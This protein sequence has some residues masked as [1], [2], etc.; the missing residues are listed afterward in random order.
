MKIAI[1][2]KDNQKLDA[3]VYE[4]FGKAPF[5]T[6]VDTE[7]DVIRTESNKAQHFDGSAR[8][9]EVMAKSDIDI[10]LCASLG[11]KAVSLFQ[12]GGI[13]IFS[14]AQSKV[15]DALKAHRKGQLQ[16]ATEANACW[17]HSHID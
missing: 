17:G 1:P 2:T 14:G 10:V 7:T 3:T 15:R 12:D 16:P 11:R 8:P 4:H 13:A 9:A 6:I 5:Y